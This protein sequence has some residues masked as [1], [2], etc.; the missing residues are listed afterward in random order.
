MQWKIVCTF[1]IEHLIRFISKIA[2]LYDPV[3]WT[4]NGIGERI[5]W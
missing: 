5:F 1:D 3:M 2:V 4:R